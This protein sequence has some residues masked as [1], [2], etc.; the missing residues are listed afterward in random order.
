M[1]DEVGS[2]LRAFDRAFALGD[3]SAARDIAKRM[4]KDAP[5]A[6][7]TRV[8]LAR[9]EAVEG[10][11]K[12]ALASLNA[13][14]DEHGGDPLPRAY[15]G[16]ILVALGEPAAAIPELMA[17]LD[18]DDADVP[19]AHHA[20]GVALLL[21][22]RYDEAHGHLEA[23]VEKLPESA[24][25]RF[26]LGQAHEARGQVD[27]AAEQYEKSTSIEPGYVDAWI[28]RV[29]LRAVAGD[30]QSAKETLA[31]ALTHNPNEPEL[32][33]LRVQIALDEGD[34]SGAR[35]ALLDI[36]KARRDVEDW[37]NL[38][39]F[40]L[41]ES[42]WQRAHAHAEQAERT[43][44]EHWWPPYLVGI[45]LEGLA[46]SRAEVMDAYQRSIDNGDPAGE[47]G[48]RLGFVMIS[49]DDEDKDAPHAVVVLEQAARRNKRAAGTLL[50]LAIACENAGDSA[51]AMKL[52]HEIL[53]QDDA[54]PPVR[55]QAERLV[56]ALKS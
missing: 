17:A 36:P 33:R 9:L 14:A 25:P 31:E 45:A 19:A 2:D 34:P 4:K 50:N 23:A 16:S 28:G 53:G 8:V 24:A 44:G 49:G 35:Q 7:E 54:P 55:E 42:D 51:R 39:V 27:A 30:L 11:P 15:A 37:C 3:V 48:T 22:G 29:R 10:D 21:L 5:S 32:M 1:A 12:K 6:L 56:E 41:Q 52:A 43:D 13:L 40:A 47:A 18:D 46:R 38:A 20:M 26:Y